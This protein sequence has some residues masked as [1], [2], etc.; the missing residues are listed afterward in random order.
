MSDRLPALEAMVA[1]DPGDAFARY[2]LGQEYLAAGRAAD[3]ATHLTAYCESFEGDKGAACLSLAQA[4]EALG[5][6][7]GAVAALELGVANARAHRH[8]QLVASLEAERE[9]LLGR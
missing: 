2:L 4:R 1:A 9:R 8:L 7:A 5:D 6:A 3:A